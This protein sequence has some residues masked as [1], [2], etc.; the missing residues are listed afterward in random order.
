ASSGYLT[1]RV[2][3][4]RHTPGVR[5]RLAV[6]LAATAAVAAA[7]AAAAGSCTT[8]PAPRLPRSGP[9]IR[10]GVDPEAAGDV[11][12]VQSPSKPENRAKALAALHRLAV[13]GKSLVVPM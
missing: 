5:S 11:G 1:R 2:S 3:S 8:P 6:I 10:F 12:S 9:A 4:R 7:P 13:P